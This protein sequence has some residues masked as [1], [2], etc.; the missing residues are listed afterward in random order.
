MSEAD[1]VYDALAKVRAVEGLSPTKWRHRKGQTKSLADL[2]HTDAPAE[3]HDSGD[4][5][6]DECRAGRK[7]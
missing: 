6:C 1:E 2:L 5:D 7:R 3:N 4:C